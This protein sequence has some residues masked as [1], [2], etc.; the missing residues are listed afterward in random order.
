MLKHTSIQQVWAE[1]QASFVSNTPQM[2]LIVQPKGSHILMTPVS[3]HSCI[4]INTNHYSIWHFTQVYPASPT[5]LEAF[6]GQGIS[7]TCV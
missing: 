5:K 6:W 2:T 3:C 7:L 4:P 1:A